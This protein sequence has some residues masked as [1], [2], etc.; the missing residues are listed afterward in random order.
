MT[1]WKRARTNF[2][3]VPFFLLY[4][5]K[6]LR[7]A[8]N[9]IESWNLPNRTRKGS[10]VS[11]EK[12]EWKSLL[13][14]FY[15]PYDGNNMDLLCCI[16]SNSFSNFFTSKP[17]KDSLRWNREKKMRNRKFSVLHSV[18][19]LL[20][21]CSLFIFSSDFLHIHAKTAIP[22][23]FICF[24][25]YP[26]DIFMSFKFKEKCLRGEFG[27]R[28]KKDQ[29]EVLFE[30]WGKCQENKYCVSSVEGRKVFDFFNPKHSEE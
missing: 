27:W 21:D 5:N 30:M 13:M 1:L 23:S 29:H 20:R 3:S 24:I 25:V 14:L 10:K 22:Y 19:I 16:F 17:L 7:F 26:W 12:K 28:A 18:F 2:E 9:I 4:W 6:Y 15:E 8:N 11:F